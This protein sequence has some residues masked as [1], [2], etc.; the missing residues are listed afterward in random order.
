[1][2]A[3]VA[4]RNE[5]ARGTSPPTGD[6]KGPPIHLPSTLAPTEPGPVFV[7]HL[8]PIALSTMDYTGHAS[9]LCT[10]N[11]YHLLWIKRPP[12]PLHT[13]IAEFVM[14]EVVSGGIIEC[15]VSHRRTY[16]W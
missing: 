16:G 4:L 15:N 13:T 3:R 8:T 9:P 14:Q 12:L 2:V 7:L 10:S 5:P 6:H 1:M 11:V